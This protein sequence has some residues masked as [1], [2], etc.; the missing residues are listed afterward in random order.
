MLA[1]GLI[2]ACVGLHGLL[3]QA[4][5]TPAAGLQIT[6]ADL[7][8]KQGAAGDGDELCSYDSQP[9]LQACQAL[10]LDPRTRQLPK[11]R[12]YFGFQHAW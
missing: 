12:P 8:S 10:M 2:S 1:L 7:I 9:C 11:L 4:L 3:K 5:R 6:A